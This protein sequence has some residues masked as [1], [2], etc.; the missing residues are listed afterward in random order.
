M[1]LRKMSP[2][3]TCLYSAASM[4]RR[5]AL[6]AAHSWASKP[7]LAA[8]APELRGVFFRFTMA[9]SSDLFVE[10]VRESV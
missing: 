4:E 3:T 1:Y 2:S 8:V 7:R 6:A 9:T 10:V 5:R